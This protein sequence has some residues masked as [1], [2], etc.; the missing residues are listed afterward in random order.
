MPILLIIII[1]A[2]IVYVAKGILIVQQ[3]EV[4]IIERLGKYEKTLE[5]GLNFIF[6]ILEA[7]R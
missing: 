7:P 5:S 6:P 1:V 4:M 3:A 2:I